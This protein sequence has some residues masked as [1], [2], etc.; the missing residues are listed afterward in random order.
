MPVIHYGASARTVLGMR[1]RF[2]GVATTTAAPSD[3]SWP[4]WDL[5][6]AAADYWAAEF[7]TAVAGVLTAAEAARLAA[8]YLASEPPQDQDAQTA[9]AWLTAQGFDLAPALAAPAAGVVADGFLI[10]AASAT[11]VANGTPADVG[12]WQP[13]D[14]DAAQAQAEALGAGAAYTAAQKTAAEVAAAAAASFALAMAAALTAGAGATAAAIAAAL[15]AAVRDAGHAAAIVL[16][17]ITAACG[18]A[19]NA[20]YKLLGIS[21]AFWM[22]KHD[23]RVCDVCAANAAS[24]SLPIGAAY[25]SGDI[26]PPAHPHCRCALMPEGANRPDATGRLRE[27]LLNER[28]SA[29]SLLEA[30]NA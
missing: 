8:A 30:L 16:D 1:D 5:D 9:A 2:M 24:E 10:G 22:A 28:T 25:P 20:M 18:A 6:E 4:G 11:A 13:G 23:T 14:T 3:P 21:L 29:D 7:T 12:A 19:A 15:R 26:T 17:H 27:Y